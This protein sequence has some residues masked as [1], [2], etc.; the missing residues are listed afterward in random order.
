MPS[1]L[2]FTASEGVTYVQGNALPHPSYWGAFPRKLRKYALQEKIV[3]FNDAIRSMTSLPAEKFKLR[4]RGQIAIGNFADIAIID[5]KKIKDKATFLQPEQYAEGVEYL[6]VNGII[7]LERGKVTG[8][9]GGRA[10]RR[11]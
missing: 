1:Q 2:V 3:H 9:K 8:K 11:I 4:G 7:C 5:L 10:L 6:V